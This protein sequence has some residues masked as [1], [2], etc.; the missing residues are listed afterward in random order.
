[1]GL[2]MP[3]EG[4]SISAQLEPTAAQPFT[5]ALFSSPRGRSTAENLAAMYSGVRRR[6][7]G[8]HILPA[9]QKIDSRISG[10]EVLV[11]EGRPALWATLSN[12][13]LLPF[14]Q[15]GEAISSVAGYLLCLA[16]QSV[17]LVDEVENGLHYSV[18]DQVWRELFDEAQSQ[19]HQVIATT[20]SQ[21]CLFAAWRE[22]RHEKAAL[23]LYRLTR[24]AE[25]DGEVRAVAYDTDRLESG[26]EMAVEL[27]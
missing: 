16:E 7:R 3:P 25:D 6:S 21:E 23:K 4:V 2:G 1:M 14:S 19:G 18:M 24:G 26:I 10:I 9:L 12:G 20:H 13:T 8:E 5:T 22:L 17:L 11:S 27:R 15:L